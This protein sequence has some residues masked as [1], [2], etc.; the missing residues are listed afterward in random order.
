MEQRRNRLRVM[1]EEE[2]AR[3]E[4]ELREVVPDT[5]T[6]AS[7]LL[8]KTKELRTVREERR[9]KVNSLELKLL[10]SFIFSTNHGALPS[11]CHHNDFFF[12]L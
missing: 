5:G 2:H 8:Q 12:Y 4:A 1:L 7:Q 6:L 10:Y 9:K 11:V 3:L